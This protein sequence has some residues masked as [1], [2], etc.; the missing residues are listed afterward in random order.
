MMTEPNAGGSSILSEV[1]SFEMLNYCFGASL[2]ATE[3][4]LEYNWGSKITDYSCK[5]NGHIY[6]V[7]VTRMIDF[8]DLDKK[9]K[10]TFTDETVVT[11]LNKKLQGILSSTAGVYDQYKWEKQILHVWATSH[12]VKQAFEELYE[13]ADP[14][15]KANTVVLISVTEN[16]KWIF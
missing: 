7:S 14:F 5:I 10:A 4:E 12:F 8:D 1:L 2:V 16:A 3:M 15:L 6:G 9:H 11:L 13:L